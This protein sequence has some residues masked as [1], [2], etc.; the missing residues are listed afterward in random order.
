LTIVL[1]V[2]NALLNALGAHKF[3]GI[4]DRVR[5][6]LEAKLDLVGTNAKLLKNMHACA[7]K[8]V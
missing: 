3:I 4:L 8:A 5:M 1:C 7:S 2:V 6:R